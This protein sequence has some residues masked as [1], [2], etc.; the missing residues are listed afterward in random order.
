MALMF[1]QTARIK[2]AVVL[3]NNIDAAKFPR[4][5]SR[6]LQKL[7]LRD[8]HSF[9]EEEQEKL[10]VALGLEGKDLQLVLETTSFIL[11]QAAY[12]I[13]KPTV[14]SQQLQNIGLEEDKVSVFVKAWTSSG[15]GVVEKL[16]QRTLA[17][18]QLEEVNW[19][20]NLQMGQA[21]Q[22][23]MKLP[24]AMFEMVVSGQEE[25]EKE[26]IKM[27]FSHDELYQFYN[28]LEAIQGQLDSMS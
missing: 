14:L 12:H 10:Q 7:H 27:E 3:I 4:L 1:S 5:L 18:N 2:K 25:G 22:T 20:L 15:K 24:N 17:P 8:D 6:I 26:K 13:A 11:E 19:R 23:K 16:R 9:S 28:K 21:S